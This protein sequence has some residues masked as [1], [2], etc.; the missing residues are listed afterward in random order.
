MPNS[1]QIPPAFVTGE[2][3]ITHSVCQRSFAANGPLQND[4]S[5]MLSPD[6]YPFIGSIVQM[7][8]AFLPVSESHLVPNL[9]CAVKLVLLL[10]ASKGQRIKSSLHQKAGAAWPALTDDQH[11]GEGLQGYHAQAIG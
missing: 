7:R 11:V 2:S 3:R 4:R 10:C 5:I 8:N 1:L 6:S 9:S